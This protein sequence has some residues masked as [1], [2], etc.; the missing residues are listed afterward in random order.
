MALSP[1]KLDPSSLIVRVQYPN[2]CNIYESDLDSLLDC[3]STVSFVSA[4]AHVLATG[5]TEHFRLHLHSASSLQGQIRENSH[6]IGRKLHDWWTG[7]SEPL[8]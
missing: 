8:L 7:R 2:I 5:P 1:P 4:I 6:Q 3:L